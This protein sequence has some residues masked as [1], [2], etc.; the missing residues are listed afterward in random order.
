MGERG[1]FE[2]E[3]IT[4]VAKRKC[5][6]SGQPAVSCYNPF[7][8]NFKVLL[9]DHPWKETRVE[10]EALA[11]LGAVLV[12]APDG[13]EETLAHLAADVDAIATCWAPV[14]R[15]VI[16]AATRC[17]VISRMGIGLDNIDLQAAAGRG[18]PVTNVPDYC[19][20]E[21]ADHTLA[22]ILALHRK[23][24]F[25]HLRTKRGEYDLRAGT[26]IRRLQG[27][28]LGLLGL[29]RIGRAVHQRAQVFGLRVIAHTSSGHDHGTGCRMVDLPVLLAES[30]IISLHVPL[31][32]R[33]RHIVNDRTISRM[34]AGAT[35][36]N[37]SRGGLIDPDALWRGLQSG[38]IAGAG[39]DVFEPEPPDLSLPL[40]Q[41]ERVI[42]TPHAAFVSTEAVL[43]LRRRVFQQIVDVLS[44]RPPENVVQGRT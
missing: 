39:L 5:L 38:V 8:A 13:D 12:D 30:D 25:F 41:D 6:D 17:R 29:G 4:A 35:L 43:E 33:T 36:I 31:T 18:I 27:Q 16:E 28:A 15:K 21:V 40:Y 22:L 3:A 19:V 11:A 20:E 7:M 10:Q 37:T 32:D 42:A 34:R 26:P 14:T 23:I 2:G 24:A 44:G 1:H 9:T